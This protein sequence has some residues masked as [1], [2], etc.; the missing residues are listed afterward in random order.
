MTEGY[1]NIELIAEL[2]KEQE[3]ERDDLVE[4]IAQLS[5]RKWIRQAYVDFVDN[6]N[7]NQPN[8]E[9]QSDEN[10]VLEHKN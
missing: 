6:S 10:I 5:P 2:L 7:P 1:F 9:W 4:Q 8:S 3:P